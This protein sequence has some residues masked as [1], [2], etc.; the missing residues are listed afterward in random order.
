VHNNNNNKYSSKIL[1]TR[2]LHQKRC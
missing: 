1:A 2:I